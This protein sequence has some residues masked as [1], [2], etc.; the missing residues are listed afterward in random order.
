M[1]QN[2]PESR[3]VRPLDRWWPEPRMDQSFRD[4]V[5][6]FFT[7]EGVDR[8]FE[9]AHLVKVEET[10]EDGVHVV[11]AELPGIDPEKNVEIDVTDGLLHIGAER[12]ERSE[13]ARGEGYRTEFRYGRFERTIRLP[14]GTSADAIT[15]SY[16]DGILEVRMPVT[17]HVDKPVSRIPVQKG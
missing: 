17:E 1:S 3:A 12:E 8:L 15:A 10:V 9:G 6:G 5:R 14:E 11:R 16:K 7:A 4:M 2:K 13:E